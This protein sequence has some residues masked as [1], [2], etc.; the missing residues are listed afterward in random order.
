MK[1]KQTKHYKNGC[2]W[3]EIIS[4]YIVW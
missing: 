1:Q 3:Y 2:P 4:Q